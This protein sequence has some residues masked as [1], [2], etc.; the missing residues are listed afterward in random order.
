LAKFPEYGEAFQKD[1]S[2]GSKANAL[3]FK[4]AFVKEIV[5]FKGEKV[6]SNDISNIYLYQTEEEI[7]KIWD[8]LPE[9]NA[10]STKS[11]SY[12]K[13]GGA[14]D[15]QGYMN[16][17]AWYA[18]D[19]KNQVEMGKIDPANFPTLKIGEPKKKT[20]PVAPRGLSVAAS[21]EIKAQFPLTIRNNLGRAKR[22]APKFGVSIKDILM[23]ENGWSE[24]AA[25]HIIKNY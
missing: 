19:F 25:E 15:E 5:D 1:D 6:Q 2:K 4:G 21:A 22:R 18:N 14:T 9:I 12:W 23:D 10:D 3:G 13:T 8:G 16:Y 17:R 7:R 11:Q 24:E 20:V